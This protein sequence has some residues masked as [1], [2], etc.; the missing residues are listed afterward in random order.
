MMPRVAR[1]RRPRIALTGEVSTGE[2]E[3]N[4]LFGDH[5]T[6]RYNRLSLTG[7]L[8]TSPLLVGSHLLTEVQSTIHEYH[9]ENDEQYRF[10]QTS[11]DANYVFATR[12]ALGFAYIT[13]ARSG[14][15]PF[16]FDQVD[17]QDE[18]QVRGEAGFGSRKRY[19]LAAVGRYDLD[20]RR[21][22]DYEIAGALRGRNIEPRLSYRHL[23]RQ[24]NFAVSFPGITSL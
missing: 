3:E 4:R 15:T 14:A 9:Y 7:G 23:N 1:L 13:R 24:Y 8:S 18:G 11:V 5:D 17:T 22:F 16:Y 19:T 20:Q 12:T 6:V 10:L 21:F 2:Y